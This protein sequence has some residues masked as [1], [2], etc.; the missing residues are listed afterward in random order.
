MG[1]ILGLGMSH[2][3]GMR[4]PAGGPA[5]LASVLNRPDIPEEAK[6][7]K[8]WPPDAAKEFGDDEGRTAHREH[9]EAFVKECLHLREQLDR[10]NPD[11][12]IIWGDDQY[13]NFK[14]D[15]I[16]AFCIFAYEDMDIHPYVPERDLV[17]PKRFPVSA[18]S[19][20]V[21]REPP[22]NPWGEPKDTV[23]PVRGKREAGKF[24]AQ[25]LIEEGV[26]I[27]YAYEPLHHGG[28]AHAFLN[29]IMFLDWERKG[30]DYPVVSFQVNC[31]GSRVIVNR[32]GTFPVD[33]DPSEV[34]LDPPGPTP[35]R[36]MEVG[37]AVARVLQRS[38]WRVAL[39]AS[40]SWS[41]AF[42]TPKTNFLFPD[43]PAD[44]KL[45]EALIEGNYKYWRGIT[46]DQVDDSGQQE[47]RNWWT[48]MGAMEELGHKEPT[49]HNYI[50]SYTMNSN[51]CFA[52]WEPR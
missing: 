26:D 18:F 19:L 2:Y 1:E 52:V 25:G 12:V 9:K 38:P 39:I 50:E 31:Y 51:K 14:E 24:L 35:A 48:L 28:L 13:E 7:P 44:R 47:V 43:V 46:N 11:F 30:F 21:D 29:T 42:L 33:E 3:P 8:N 5:S 4:T 23:I 32:G 6:D 34:D 10:F 20:P 49:Y 40:S 27:A 16:P 15:I 45:Y 36:C 37:A 17:D 22:P 41:H